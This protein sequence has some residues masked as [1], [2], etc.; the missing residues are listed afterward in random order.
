M[1]SRLTQYIFAAS[2]PSLCVGT[3]CLGKSKHL[4]VEKTFT[5]SEVTAAALVEEG[6]QNQLVVM[7]ALTYVYHPLFGQVRSI[8]HSGS[9]GEVRHVEAHF[10]F[11]YLPETDIRNQAQL[12]GGAILDALIYPLSFCL[13]ILGDQYNSYYSNIV[14]DRTSQNRHEGIP[15]AGLG[16]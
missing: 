1:T 6:K 10:G 13:Y 5:H 12:G 3:S 14:F 8:A 9:L 16:R 2:R 4:L 11:P 7:E 15:A